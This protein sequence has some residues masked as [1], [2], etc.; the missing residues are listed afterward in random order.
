[1]VEA[2]FSCLPNSFGIFQN[3]YS[4]QEAFKDSKSIPIIGTLGLGLAFMISPLVTQFVAFYPKSPKKLIYAGLILSVLACLG[5]SFAKTVPQLIFTQGVMLG[6]GIALAYLPT[7]SFINEWFVQRRGLASG[8][9]F[10]GAGVTGLVLPILFEKSLAGLG[11]QWTLR[12]W[13]IA[14]AI[15]ITPSI[16]F[17]IKGRLPDS[18]RTA[19]RKINFKFLRNPVFLLVAVTNLLQGMAF[20]IPTIF[21]PSYAADL[22]IPAIQTSLLLSFLNLAST[23]GQAFTGYLADRVGSGVPF[24]F[25]TIVGGLS[26]CL[27]WGLSKSYAPLVLF[28]FV[29]GISAGGYSVL[30]PKFAWEVASDDPHTQ[31]LLVGFLYFER[32]IGNV[33][34]G[35]ISSAL[36]GSQRHVQSYAISKY[37]SMVLFTGITMCA[38][39]LSIL[40]RFV[41]RRA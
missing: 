35:P 37:E 23:L 19:R 11:Y 21:L 38:G 18:Q 27:I 17:L 34:S 29:Y 8:I 28:S 39:C 3:Y 41:K 24:F 40:G 13:A 14:M 31:L 25:S 4:S 10:G 16:H 7:L 26:I 20:F 36:L 5:A 2:M 12:L 22:R 33:L 1:M 30:Y 15:T 32:G 9:M 6:F